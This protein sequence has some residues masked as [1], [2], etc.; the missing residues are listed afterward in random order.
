LRRIYKGIRA[1]DIRCSIKDILIVDCGIELSCAVVEIV[2]PYCGYI[3]HILVAIS[4][5]EAVGSCDI[6]PIELKIRSGVTVQNEFFI[7]PYR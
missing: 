3:D 7:V 1:L 2:C 6:N 4:D 5:G